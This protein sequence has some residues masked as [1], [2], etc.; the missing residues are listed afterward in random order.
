MYN[1]KHPAYIIAL[2]LSLQRKP[3][4]SLLEHFAM[5]K[6]FFFVELEGS[7]KDSNLKIV[8]DSDV[9]LPAVADIGVGKY[10]GVHN[11]TNKLN[12]NEQIMESHLIC[13]HTSPDFV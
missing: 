7:F 12:A 2:S 11:S 5:A 8:A 13:R 4:C 3:L 1:L 9:V 10:S 6:M